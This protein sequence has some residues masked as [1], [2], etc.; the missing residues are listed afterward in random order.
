[1]L[2]TAIFLLYLCTTGASTSELSLQRSTKRYHEFGGRRLS[3]APL[4]SAGS[5]ENDI[6]GQAA[7]I[8][9]VTQLLDKA[10]VLMAMASTA[11]PS[12]WDSATDSTLAFQQ[13]LSWLH[14]QA[15]NLSLA[16]VRFN[17][18]MH[19]QP[20]ICG[21]DKKAA[22]HMLRTERQRRGD[23]RYRPDCRSLGRRNQEEFLEQQVRRIRFEYKLSCLIC[24]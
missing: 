24:A 7:A 10:G 22:R 23:P 5:L 4:Q 13:W 9:T 3:S 19:D 12:P 18:H 11:Q 16:P 6:S 8:K 20:P 14:V 2:N 17:G 15:F 1:M 21:K